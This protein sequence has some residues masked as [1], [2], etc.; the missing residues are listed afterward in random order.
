MN[1]PGSMN[2]THVVTLSMTRFMTHSLPMTRPVS[3]SFRT[4]RA[5]PMSRRPNSL[6]ALAGLTLSLLLSGCSGDDDDVSSASPR[7]D[8]SLDDDAQ[9]ELSGVWEQRGYGNLYVFENNRTTLYSLNEATCLEISSFDGVA[10]L[11]D[12][13]LEMSRFG[14]DGDDLSLLIAGSAYPIRLS[15]LDAVPARCEEP[16]ANDPQAVFDYVWNTFDE[17]YA[18]FE[19]RGV[20]WAA[21]YARQLPRVGDVD[22]D[23]ALFTLLSD[24]LSPIDDRNV[25]L[26]NDDAFYSPAVESGAGLALRQAFEAQDA[27]DDF[28][29]FATTVIDQLRA[30]LVSRMDPESFVQEGALG[31]ATAEEGSIG[32]I[33]IEAMEGY[34][35]DDAGERLENPSDLEERLSAQDVM[36]RAMNDLASTSRLIVDVRLNGGGLDSVALDFASR[37][38]DERQ[39]AFSKQARNRNGESVPVDAYLEPPSTGAYLNPLTLIVGENTAGAAEVFAVAL[40]RQTQVTVIGEQTAGAL[41]DTLFKPLPNRWFTTLPNEVYLDAEGVSYEQVGLAPAIEVPVFRVEDILAGE[42]QAL[43]LALSVP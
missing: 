6:L 4:R 29:A 36:D 37:F 30:T 22:D 41:S 13:E 25:R 27:I 21:E 9:L 39:L 16:V 18:F 10:G 15:R 3:R 7:P 31:W 1:M 40:R 12:E 24:L 35:V 42:D 19:L 17:Y 23:E 20:D 11:S 43:E 38:V 14:L 33:F 34:A 2:M 32:Y 26:F 5:I 28:N 8:R